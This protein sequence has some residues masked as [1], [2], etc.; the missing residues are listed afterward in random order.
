MALLTYIAVVENTD[1][2][3]KYTKGV[4]NQ[5]PVNTRRPLPIVSEMSQQTNR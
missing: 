2:F 3:D 5:A 4:G 1:L